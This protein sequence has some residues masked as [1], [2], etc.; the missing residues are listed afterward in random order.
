[1]SEEAKKNRK[2]EKRRPEDTYIGIRL[3]FWLIF[4]GLVALST[5]LAVILA[6]L[7]VYHAAVPS[8]WDGS[9]W[10]WVL[11]GI[12]AASFI[13]IAIFSGR[14]IITWA[15][16]LRYARYQE[17]R[18]RAAI[19]ARDI[20]SYAEN[21]ER[22]DK[23]LR[24]EVKGLGSRVEETLK[25]TMSE[26]MGKTQNSIMD[27]MKNMNDTIYSA[28]KNLSDRVSRM[29]EH[30]LPYSVTE[31]TIRAEKNTP[32]IARRE[33]NPAQESAKEPEAKEEP[34][35]ETP[36]EAVKAPTRRIDGEIE[37]ND[38]GEIIEEGNQMT[39]PS[40]DES[41]G[42]AEDDNALFGTPESSGDTSGPAEGGWGFDEEDEEEDEDDEDNP[43]V[44]I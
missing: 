13:A 4:Y 2:K 40:G 10:P 7:T 44:R 5:A 14:L 8:F 29:E 26:S 39:P 43:L 3:P 31:G 33:E 16:L 19:A 24:D 22:R 1:M 23:E 6:M 15:Q 28:I 27:A 12:S 42:I 35:E 18:S 34:E 32:P 17:A 25:S 38:G 9:S 21:E 36:K 11:I 30:A 41:E 20:T 37:I